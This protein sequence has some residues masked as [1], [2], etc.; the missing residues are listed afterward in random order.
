MVRPH[1]TRHAAIRARHFRK[2]MSWSEARLWTRLKGKQIGVKFRRQVPIGPYITDFACLD[3]KVVLEVDGPSHDWKDETDRTDFL[4]A[5][6][7][8]VIRVSNEAI[9]EDVD[10]VVR[11]VRSRIG[12]V[13][14]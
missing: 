12:L 4:E 13:D 7:F 11:Y 3:P 5:Q 6:G 10:Q 9:K 8:E 2:H 14:E 1:H